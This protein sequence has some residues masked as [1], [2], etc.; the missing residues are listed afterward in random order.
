MRLRF[1]P[2]TLLERTGL[3]LGLMPV[4][5]G[6]TFLA[7]AVARTVGV[8]QKLGVFRSLARRPATVEAL[9]GEL[10]VKRAALRM[11]LDLLVGER[12]L[13]R[14]G[15]SRRPP[16]RYALAAQGRRWL[17]PASRSYLGTYVEHTLDY[18]GWWSELERVVREGGSFAIH[19][20][21]SDNASW[22][23][24]IRGQYELA[25][26][27]SGEVARIVPLPRGAR[28]LL[29]VAGGHGWYAAAIC[30]RHP[31]LRATVLDLP[32]S[33]RVG[34]EIMRE[35]GME[36]RVRHVEG[37]ALAADLG[38]PHNAAL[39]FSILHHLEPGKA[40]ELL[41]RIRAALRPG[42]LVA[43]LDLFQPGPDERARA[44]SAATA[45][46]FHLTS[47]V[48]TPSGEELEG[49]LSEAGYERPVRHDLKTLPDL[50]VYVAKAG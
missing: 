18:L 17:D 10:G 48:E 30:R 12:L 46:F 23:R 49:W 32:G 29:D 40:V 41:R 4:P 14:V 37:D 44:S 33:A 45:L 38:G 25:R 20:A 43:V 15:S 2:D 35:A 47:G 9:A 21:P 39:C 19:E 3:A 31:G 24:Y 36:E 50:R 13:R 27:S 6:Q 1:A 7:L 5:V 26:L 42:G 8:A 11:V 28:S 22:D 34:R 16:V